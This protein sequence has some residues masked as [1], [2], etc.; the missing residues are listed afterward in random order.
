[1]AIMTASLGIKNGKNWLHL[2]DGKDGH[3]KYYIIFCLQIKL[4]IDS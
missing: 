3:Y 2:K 1:M 4:Q